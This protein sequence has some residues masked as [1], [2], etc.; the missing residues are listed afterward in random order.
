[1]AKVEKMVRV[2]MPISVHR[3]VKTFAAQNDLTLA[4]AYCQLVE[5][6]LNSSKEK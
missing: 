4:E 3:K 5:K 2:E 6:A 1:M